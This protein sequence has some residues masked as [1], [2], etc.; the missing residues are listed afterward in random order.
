MG[1]MEGKMNLKGIGEAVH[2]RRNW[3][4][5]VHEVMKS[6]IRLND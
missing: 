6:W 2:D 4:A 3:Y 5:K 1:K